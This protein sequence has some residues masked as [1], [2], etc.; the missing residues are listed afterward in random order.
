[1]H[2]KSKLAEARHFLNRMHEEDSNPAAFALELSAFMG[3]ARSVLQYAHKE[4][5][6]K[7]C[8]QQWYDQTM[9]NPLLC[10]FR[11]LRNDSTHRVP[12]EPLRRFETAVAGMLNIG[13]E[14]GEILIPHPHVTTVQ[15]YEFS[16]RPGE[17]V[18]DLSQQY[19]K[20]LEDL[21]EDGIAKKWITG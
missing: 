1:M 21:V 12:V 11:N 2:E 16:S 6:G 4:A 5:M 15:R 7:S 8:G 10:F 9:T 18:T 13:D 14:D 19:L 17:D 3:A 20:A